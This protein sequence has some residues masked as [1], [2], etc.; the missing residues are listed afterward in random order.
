MGVNTVREQFEHEYFLEDFKGNNKM[1]LEC[2]FSSMGWN[3]VR[4]YALETSAKWCDSYIHGIQLYA[5]QC[6]V[7]YLI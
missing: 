6:Y 4:S 7:N 3:K 5:L 1:M 2:R